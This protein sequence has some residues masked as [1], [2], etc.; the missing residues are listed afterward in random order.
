MSTT[1]Q[2]ITISSDSTETS[3]SFKPRRH[4][5]NH[6]HQH[7]DLVGLI[8]DDHPQYLNVD[9][10]T[11]LFNNLIDDTVSDAIASNSVTS[12]ATAN[13]STGLPLIKGTDTIGDIT[14]YSIKAGDGISLSLV[15]DDIVITA[16]EQTI[17]GI[18]GGTY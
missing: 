10:A 16:S 1:N 11:S 12:I 13:G 18:D 4:V 9:R 3:G 17:S 7:H 14:L 15:N 8:D 2:T 5:P 6:T